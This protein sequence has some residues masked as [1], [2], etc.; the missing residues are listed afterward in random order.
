[1]TLTIIGPSGTQVVLHETDIGSMTSH[2]DVGGRINSVGTLSGWGTYTGVTIN[3]FCDLV[4]G[5]H[6]SQTLRVT[7]SDNYNMTFTYAQVNGDFATYN[8]TKHRV[9]HTQPLT[10]ILAYHFNDM[11]LTSGGPLRFAIVGPEGLY[12]N[13][14]YWVQKVVKLE[15]LGQAVGGYVNQIDT[16][17]LLAPWISLVSIVTVATASVIASVVYLRRRKRQQN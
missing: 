17:G 11:N 15:I 7:A 2:R 10:T 13:S 9:N 12:T 8:A 6:S 14:T 16:I 1:M 3:T 5:I 4:G